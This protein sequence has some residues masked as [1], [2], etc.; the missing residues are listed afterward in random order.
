M[1]LRFWYQIKRLKG[2]ER[3]V[4]EVGLK[5]QE[6]PKVYQNGLLPVKH[7]ST[8]IECKPVENHEVP[9]VSSSR[10]EHGSMTTKKGELNN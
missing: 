10:S 4:E 6:A 8:D 2:T 7:R 9:V 3:T 5:T 1:I